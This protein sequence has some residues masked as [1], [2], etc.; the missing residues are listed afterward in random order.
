MSSQADAGVLINAVTAAGGDPRKGPV[1]DVAFEWNGPPRSFVLLT[2]GSLRVS[3]RTRGRQVP[4]AECRALGGQDCMPVS[5]AILA[6]SE[7]AVRAVCLKPSAWL[8][9]PPDDFR[10]MVSEDVAFRR[11]LFRQHASRLPAFFART[12]GG[13][14]I[15][16]RLAKW[17]LDR[18]L[19]TRIDV[20]HQR[21]ASDLLT[22]REVASRT[23]KRFADKGWIEQGRGWIEVLCPAA[24]AQLALLSPGPA[25]R[26]GNAAS[27]PA[28]KPAS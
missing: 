14:S 1:G 8:M 22:A 21:I 27:Q 13:M 15:D 18:P 10:R 11:A 28:G 26:D 16:Q 20:T 7:L 6:R 24:L 5:A 3:F 9:L 4:W 17:L 19:D 23:L 25:C 12:T 2:R